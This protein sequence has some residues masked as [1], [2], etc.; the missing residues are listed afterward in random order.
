[1]LQTLQCSVLFCFSDSD[2]ASPCRWHL[3]DFT[4]S[5]FDFRWSS[6]QHKV[7][8]FNIWCGCNNLDLH[9][10]FPFHPIHSHTGNVF[11]IQ[12]DEQ[13]CE[14]CL[15]QGHFNTWTSSGSNSQSSLAVITPTIKM[16]FCLLL[17]L[18]FS[19][20]YINCFCLWPQRKPIRSLNIPFFSFL[21]L[22]VVIFNHHILFQVTCLG[23]NA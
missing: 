17:L 9:L 20:I 4:H 16:G 23:L 15:P 2:C 11:F 10:M 3:P 21:F 7:I 12:N 5:A 18:F 1:M 6:I 8:F 14:D 19:N 22:H 13:K